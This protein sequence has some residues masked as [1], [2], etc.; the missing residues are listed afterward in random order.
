LPACLDEPRFSLGK[1]KPVQ[2]R[3]RHEQKIAA[4]GHQILMAAKN[5]AQPPLGRIPAHGRTHRGGRRHDADPDCRR[6][7]CRP[8]FAP[9][10]PQGEGPAVEAS[11]LRAHAAEIV[12]APQMLLGAKV[13]G[14]KA[15]S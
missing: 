9:P 11:A 7:S 12:L 6:R 13:H 4:R 2:R 15:E 8:V 1:F 10:P 14:E 3:P 5:L